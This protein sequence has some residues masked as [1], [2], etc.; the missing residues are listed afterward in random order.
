V[1]TTPDQIGPP[2]Y[3]KEIEFKPLCRKYAA[4]FA[5]LTALT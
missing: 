5:E 3:T 4:H 1:V 2:D